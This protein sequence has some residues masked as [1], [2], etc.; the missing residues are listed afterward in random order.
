MNVFFCMRKMNGMGGY[1]KNK[2]KNEMKVL[3]NCN[4]HM[5]SSHYYRRRSRI[6]STPKIYP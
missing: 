3:S 4:V 5:S 2:E 6:K 1:D